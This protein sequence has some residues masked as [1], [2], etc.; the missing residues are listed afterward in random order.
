M[1]HPPRREV[2][3]VDNDG[4]AFGIKHIGNKPRVSSMPY[5]YD[6][7]EGNIADHA[8]FRI[9]GYNSDVGT[10]EEDLWAVSGAYAFPAAAQQMEVVSSAAADDGAPVGTGAQTV[11]IHYLDETYTEQEE[12]VTLN[13][14]TPVPTTA[15]NILRVNDFHTV[16]VGTGGVAAGNIDIRELDD[17]PVY[18][19][20]P[21]GGNTTLDGFWTVPLGKTAFIVSWSVGSAGGNKDARFL[22]KTTSSLAGVLTAGIF[23]NKDIAIV[24]DGALQLPFFIPV[25]VPATADIKIS[26]VS[27]ANSAICSG[28]VEGW[29]E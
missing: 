18:R 6:I 14:T 10:S 3:L 28:H 25:K 17:S 13:G 9:L 20:I 2:E 22:L 21:I 23:Q 16:A 15:E 19:R 7:A 11:M 24:E 1:S 4:T 29:Y 12:T 8:A 27:A 5:L 26:V